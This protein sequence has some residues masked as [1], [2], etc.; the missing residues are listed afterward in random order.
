M[1]FAFLFKRFFLNCKAK[2]IIMIFLSKFLI[3]KIVALSIHIWSFCFI[4]Y[5]FMNDIS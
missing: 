5:P 1:G 3:S 4:F 2:V